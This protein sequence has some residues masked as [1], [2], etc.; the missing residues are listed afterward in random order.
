VYDIQTL[1]V[2][3]Y[4]V[5][6]KDV[7]DINDMHSIHT[8]SMTYIKSTAIDIPI[9]YPDRTID[10]GQ[11]T[12]KFYHLRLRVECTPFCNLQ[13]QARTHVVLVIDLYELLGNPTH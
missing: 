6:C 1:V 4:Q 3:S 2:M 11:A 5:Q 10:H 13:S 12:G 8:T 7:N 9:G